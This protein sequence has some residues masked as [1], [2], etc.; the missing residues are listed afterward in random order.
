MSGRQRD[1]TTTKP[2]N[3]R[4]NGNGQPTVTRVCAPAYMSKRASAGFAGGT[5]ESPFMHE[6]C[7]NHP[8]ARS[9]RTVHSRCLFLSAV[10]TV[11]VAVKVTVAGQKRSYIGLP[12]DILPPEGFPSQNFGSQGRLRAKYTFA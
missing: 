11:T 9:S 2:N 12:Y 6:R 5:S 8:N 10:F 3:R 4:D 7:M 1:G